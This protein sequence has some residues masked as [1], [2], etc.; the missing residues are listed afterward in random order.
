MNMDRNKIDWIE[1]ILNLVS[2]ILQLQKYSGGFWSCTCVHHSFLFDKGIRKTYNEINL[3][4]IK[5]KKWYGW[6]PGPVVVA[7]DEN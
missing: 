7:I 3:K 1:Q 4:I 2:L 5:R 6:T